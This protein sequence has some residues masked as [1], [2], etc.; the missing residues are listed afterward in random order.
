VVNRDVPPHTLAGG[1]PARIIR[2]LDTKG[3]GVV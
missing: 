1:V 2:T 3:G